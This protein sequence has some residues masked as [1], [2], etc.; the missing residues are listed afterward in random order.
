[1]I[2]PES[3]L[4]ILVTLVSP[5]RKAAAASARHPASQLA[6]HPAVLLTRLARRQLSN[7]LSKLQSREPR[8]E[9]YEALL[10]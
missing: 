9:S 10:L 4:S 7:L 2:C 8:N 6:R 3:L 1:M 5:L